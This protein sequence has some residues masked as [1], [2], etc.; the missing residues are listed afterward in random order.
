MPIHVIWRQWKYATSSAAAPRHAL[1]AM[2]LSSTLTVAT[3]SG[4]KCRE[5][6]GSSREES[7]IKNLMSAMILFVLVRISGTGDCPGPL[8]LLRARSLSV[9]SVM[10]VPQIKKKYARTTPEKHLICA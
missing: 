1:M 8:A 4:D 3:R 2:S 9:V 10:L 6:A 7:L 5:D